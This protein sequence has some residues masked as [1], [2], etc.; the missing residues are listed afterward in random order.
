MIKNAT[1]KEKFSL[2]DDWTTELFTPIKKDLKN[3]HLKKDVKFCK[4]YMGK[5]P[6]KVQIEDLEAG[7]KQAIEDGLEEIA[8]YVFQKWLLKHSDIYDFFSNELRQINEDFTELEEIE[9]SLSQEIAK[10]STERFGAQKTYFF[11]V[12]NSVVFPQTVFEELKQL[13]L[14]ERKTK[15]QSEDHQEPEPELLAFYEKKLQ[16]VVDKY[17]KKLSG[18]EKKYFKDTQQLKKQI[19]NLQ[20]KLG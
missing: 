7:Y 14:E 6:H 12:I 13:A 15:I 8:E 10:K 5:P 1:Y 9:N 18:L 3:E 11:C 20:K 19:A 2:L 16:K 17:E 4:S